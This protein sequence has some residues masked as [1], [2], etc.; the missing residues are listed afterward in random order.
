VTV[1]F[2]RELLVEAWPRSVALLRLALGDSGERENRAAEQSSSAA[3]ART[4]MNA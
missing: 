1:V 4:L 3:M 2:V